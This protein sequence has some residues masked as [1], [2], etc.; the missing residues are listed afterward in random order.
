VP[1]QNPYAKNDVSCKTF[2]SRSRLKGSIDLLTE[3]SKSNIP[4][5]ALLARQVRATFAS[6]Y[7][8]GVNLAHILHYVCHA[9]GTPKIRVYDASCTCSPRIQHHANDASTCRAQKGMLLLAPLCKVF[10]IRLGGAWRNYTWQVHIVQVMRGAGYLIGYIETMYF[11]TNL[12][13]HIDPHR[14]SFD[15][16]VQWNLPYQ[17]HLPGGHLPIYLCCSIGKP[18]AWLSMRSI[19]VLRSHSALTSASHFL[20]RKKQSYYACADAVNRASRFRFFYGATQVLRTSKFS[21]FYSFSPLYSR[22]LS[23]K[24]TSNV[25]NRECPKLLSWLYDSFSA[26][27]FTL[28][29]NWLV[30][31]LTITI[32][33]YIQHS[34]DKAQTIF[35]VSRSGTTSFSKQHFS[36][37]VEVMVGFGSVTL[38]NLSIVSTKPIGY[39]HNTTRIVTLGLS[40]KCTSEA[41]MI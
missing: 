22:H 33:A 3:G 6:D 39:N 13:V 20:I 25:I 29:R 37:T 21:H 32:Y 19:F 5:C 1:G 34:Y 15:V 17:T 11:E 36:P 24:A 30:K 16:H 18:E 27:Y 14:C 40:V 4:C 26:P 28:A 31:L 9:N 8:S 7:S 38:L 23:I 10:S 12:R 35:N 2:T 41:L